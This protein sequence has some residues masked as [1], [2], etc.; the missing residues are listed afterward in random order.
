M[1]KHNIGSELVE[2]IRKMEKAGE[3]KIVILLL[4][5]ADYRLKAAKDQE[6]NVVNKE[7]AIA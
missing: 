7:M 4:E 3:Y 2:A 6:A 1:K 5:L